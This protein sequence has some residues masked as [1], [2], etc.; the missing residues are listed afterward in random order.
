[1]PA[2]YSHTSRASGIILTATIYNDD[3]VN[4]I[5]NGVPL[6]LDDYSSDATEMRVTT[7]PGEAGTESLATTLG[8]ELARIRFTIKEMKKWLNGGVDVAQWYT[9]ASGSVAG[10]VSDGT[11]TMAKLADLAGPSVIGRAANSSGVPAAI[12]AASDGHVLRRSGTDIGFG[13]ILLAAISDVG[14]AAAKNT[15]TSGDAVP[16]LNGNNTFSGTIALTGPGPTS[17]FAAGYR[18]APASGPQ[19]NYTFVLA[20]AGKMVRHNSGSSHTWTIPTNG[21]VAFPIGT[22]IMLVNSDT[23]TVTIARDSGVTLRLSGSATDANRTLAAHS[24]ACLVK[25]QT[26]VWYISGGVS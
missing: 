26:N 15:G 24:I 7:D 19:T 9:T 4:H 14:T 23:G 1:M 22:T 8:G 13:T 10:T 25:D 5:T 12:T 3:H 18:G 11:I 2:L 16:L 6:Q 20:D 21:D 17:E